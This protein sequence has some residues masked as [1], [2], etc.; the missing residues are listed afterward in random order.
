MTRVLL[1]VAIAALVACG[2]EEPA[3][4]ASAASREMARLGVLSTGPATVTT[5]TL[6]LQLGD[7]EYGPKALACQAGGYD[8]NSAGGAEVL[9]TGTDISQRCQGQPAMIWVVTRG[10]SVV[11]AYK[12]VRRDSM[13]APGIWAVNDPVCHD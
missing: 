5:I 7:A 6:P 13:M 3:A 11:C 1:A 10:D 4:V 2:A 8:L 12:S 9:F